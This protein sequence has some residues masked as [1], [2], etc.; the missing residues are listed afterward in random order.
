MIKKN[1]LWFQEI[2]KGDIPAVGGKGAN[3]GE[4][5][6]FAVPV[7]RGF[8]VT[9]SAYYDFLKY[10]SLA[11]KIKFEL[12]GLNIDNTDKLLLAS[13][14]IKTAILRAQM[15]EGIA[16]EIQQ[17]YHKLSGTHDVLVAVRSSATA[18][19]LPEASFAG[20]QKTFLNVTG[21]KDVVRKVQECWASLFEPRAIFYRT[22]LGFDHFKVGISAIV[23]RMVESEVSGIMFTVDPLTND[24]SRI[25]IEAVFGLG[26]AIVSGSLTPDQYLVDKETL[27]IVRKVV[28]AQDWQ[29]VRRGRVKIAAH[30]R[31]TQKIKDERIV[32][33]AKIA[34]NIEDHYGFPQDIEWSFCAGQ[35]YIVQTRPITTLKVKETVEIKDHDIDE[36]FLLA[37]IAASPGI[38]VGKVK[39]IREVKELRNVKEGEVMVTRMTRPDYVPAMK[40]CVAV[41]TDEGG[42]TS[43]AAIVSR[44][45]GVPCIVGTGQAT[46][47]LKNG[48]LVTVDGNRGR[49]YAGKLKLETE[50]VTVD[51][52]AQ[53]LKT[54]TKVYVNLADPVEAARTAALNVDGVGLLRAEFILAGIGDHPRYFLEKGRRSDFIK[55]LAWGVEQVASAFYPR[56]IIYRATDFK[57]NEYRGLKGGEKYEELEDNPLIGYRGALRYTQDNE[58]FKMELEALSYLRHKREFRNVHLMIPFVRTVPEFTEV[59]KIVGASGLHR[60]SNFKLWLMV[61]I[62]ANVLLLESFVA[63]GVDGISI[64]SNDLAMLTLGAD[65][66]NSRTSKYT[67]EDPAV[68][69]LIEEAVRRSRKLGIT[70]SICGEAP[71]TYPRL[72]RDLVKWGITS[73][74][75]NPDKVDEVRKLLHDCERELVVAHSHEKN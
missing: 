35:I 17:A 22:D 71:S 61:E 41:L 63:V 30:F 34:K 59:K 7:P 11:E 14:R 73:V 21:A 69:K 15:P 44:E 31:Q 65:R 4:M 10:G 45:L 46:S 68:Q 24:R 8:A 64:G 2:G 20:Q 9:A 72:V 28:V 75:V 42:R 6:S 52:N 55:K 27:K 26:E 51:L 48:E 18:E 57:T 29:L 67:E 53:P 5:T 16:Q 47:L 36:K 56:P 13:R 19:D 54:A 49:V 33:L 25:S 74:S 12:K 58:V 60:S 3:L 50:K 70:S 37:G 23:Q 32:E 43:H 39:I 66:D 1:I 38:A 40:R 62:P